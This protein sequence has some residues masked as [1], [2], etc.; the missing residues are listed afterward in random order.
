MAY[1]QLL[2]EF[3][4]HLFILL[5][6]CQQNG[7]RKAT[8]LPNKSVAG[9]SFPEEVTDVPPELQLLPQGL[10]QWAYIQSVHVLATEARM[11]DE[12]TLEVDSYYSLGDVDGFSLGLGSIELGWAIQVF[13]AGC[14]HFQEP[15]EHGKEHQQDVL[16]V[17]IQAL[18]PIFEPVHAEVY[19]ATNIIAAGQEMV[20]LH[21][22]TAPKRLKTNRKGDVSNIKV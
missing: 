20:E 8:E 6:V 1:A 5:A 4:D 21:I 22:G 13:L 15:R 12:D 10:R 2:D 9:R 19:S 16:T 3:I 17:V 7:V 11:V 18:G 14:Q